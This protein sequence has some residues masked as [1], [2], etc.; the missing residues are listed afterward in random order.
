MLRQTKVQ[1]LD[2]PGRIDHDVG[3]LQV[4]MHDTATVGVRQ[5]RRELVGDAVQLI[6][7]ER[8]RGK[9][10][11]K[12][13]PFDQLHDKKPDFGFVAARRRLLESVNRSNVGV[14]ESGKQLRFALE[15]RQ[16]VW[17]GGQCLRQHLDGHISAQLGVV[18]PIYLAHPALAERFEDLV[19]TEGLTDQD[20]GFL[21][22]EE[23]GGL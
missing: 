13:L 19:V 17:I 23:P 12:R 18:G 21:W 16:S 2:G 6:V 3:A 11:R 20:D 4:S 8:P 5:R 7:C 14:I 22:G 10:H 15:A 1:H 9:Q